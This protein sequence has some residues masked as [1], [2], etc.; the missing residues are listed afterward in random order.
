[1]QDGFRIAAVVPAAG[2]SSRMGSFKPLLPYADGTVIEASVG[3]ALSRAQRAVVVLGKR[4]DELR[5]LL[6]SR[7][8]D[9]LLFV[10]NPDYASTD[11]FASVKIGLRAIGE[12][13][14]FFIAPADMPLISPSVYAALADAFTGS[15]EILLP[16][17]GG[18]RGH[19]PLISAA[20]IPEILAYDGSDGLRGFYRKRKVREISVDDEGVVTDLD[21]PLDYEEIKNNN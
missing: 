16:V 13:G 1:M 9:R 2:L 8:G 7:F 21:T 20:L 6:F 14:A 18:R 19:P 11:M 17:V 4:G 15:D 12:C 10:M 3:N 5:E